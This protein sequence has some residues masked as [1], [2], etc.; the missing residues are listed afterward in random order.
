MKPPK[1]KKNIKK[2]TK[3]KRNILSKK[4]LLK[5]G[6]LLVILI[7]F[8]LLYLFINKKPAP[9]TPIHE[10]KINIITTTPLLRDLSFQIGQSR[11]NIIEVNTKKISKD[12]KKELNNLAPHCDLILWLSSDSQ[13]NSD[14]FIKDFNSPIIVF[15]PKTSNSLDYLTPPVWKKYGKKL[16]KHLS[17]IDP[18]HKTTYK[19]N[20]TLFSY[21]LHN[22]EKEIKKILKTKK[23]F[24]VAGTELHY[25]CN[26][27]NLNPQFIKKKETKVP[28]SLK[29]NFINKKKILLI[30]YNT[31]STSNLTLLQQNFSKKQTI[32]PLIL[33]L[34]PT[35]KFVPQESYLGYITLLANQI[36]HHLK[37]VP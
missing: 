32:I 6:I 35:I 22:L 12:K 1:K 26:F 2:K 36:S 20:Y 19:Q 3:S 29:K 7:L 31:I 14:S 11:L 5:V 9:L 24:I 33:T 34:D 17:K 23:A 28:Q 37:Q 21:K 25:F 4:F 27:F 13:E 18:V 10:R 30:E 16:Y 15:N 8:L